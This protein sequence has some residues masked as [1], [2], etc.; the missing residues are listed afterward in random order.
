MAR[1]FWNAKD[2]EKVTKEQIDAMTP[3]QQT[4]W[5]VDRYAASHGM[6]RKNQKGDEDYEED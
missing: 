1:R 3:E 6:T 5:E 2:P 4:T